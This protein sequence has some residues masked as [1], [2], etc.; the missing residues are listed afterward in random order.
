MSTCEYCGEEVTIRYTCKECRHK[1]CYKHRHPENHECSSLE[2]FEAKII[3]A[4]PLSETLEEYSLP[5][6]ETQIDEETTET[7]VSEPTAQKG[8]EEN[9]RRQTTEEPVSEMPVQE[10]NDEKKEGKG[11]S[12]FALL[13][14]GL[15]VVSLV[16]NGFL[17]LEYQDYRDLN[18]DYL[19]L[20]DTSIELQGYYDNLTTQYAELRLEYTQINELYQEKVKENSELEGELA[21]ILDYNIHIQLESMNTITLQPKQNY[22][23]TYE[24]PFSGYIF[25]KYN[26]SNEAY[27]WVGSTNIGNGYFSR[28]PQFPGT[29]SSYNFTVPVMPDVVIYFANPNEFEPIEISYSIDFTY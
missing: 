22:S 27:T 14:V 13:K 18:N 9:M 16:L 24:I 23:V 28:N 19:Q 21:D 10:D 2:L 1:F 29:A 7:T 26:A 17:Y 3:D 25:V 12:Y 20:Y 11:P 5:E 4:Q 8:I 6:V 15:L